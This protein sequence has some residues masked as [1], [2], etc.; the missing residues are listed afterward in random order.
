MVWSRSTLTHM[1]VCGGYCTGSRLQMFFLSSLHHCLLN[2][3]LCSQSDLRPLHHNYSFTFFLLSPS[4]LS[5]STPNSHLSPC[6]RLLLLLHSDPGRSLLV[7]LLQICLLHPLFMA[8]CCQSHSVHWDDI[9]LPL[10]HIKVSD[11]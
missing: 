10:T 8:Q 5:L 1:L 9:S 2:P 7:V 3:S 4:S 6:G 11:T